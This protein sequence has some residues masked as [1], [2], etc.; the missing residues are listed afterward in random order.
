[1]QI[2]TV[3][4]LL[5]LG[6]VLR[7][8][9]VG[10]WRRWLVFSASLVCLYWLQ[11]GLPIRGLAYWLP[12]ATLGLTAL[13][14]LLT[15]KPAARAGEPGARREDLLAAAGVV[16]AALLAGLTR[17]LGGGDWLLASA[18]PPLLQT[19]VGVSGGA[20]LLVVLGITNK[21]RALPVWALSLAIAGLVALLVVVKTPALALA[22]ARGLR[23]LAG[24]NPTLAA[25]LDV[26][27]LGFSYISFRLIHALRD[28]QN[29]RLPQAGLL[30]TIS[31]VIFFP[32]LLAGPIDRLERFDKDFRRAPGAEAHWKSFFELSEPA[33]RILLGLVKKFVLADT[34]GLA[35][36][37][38]LNAGQVGESGWMWLLVYL[39]AWQI[40]LDFA[41]YTDIAIGLGLLV[42]IKLPENF[43]APYLKPNLTQFWNA[44]HISLTQWFRGYFFNPFVRWLRGPK[45]RLK[46]AW[47][48]LLSQFATMGLIGLWH[49]VAV[50]FL[51][52][53]L[54][55]GLGL[56]V[57]NRWSD[58]TKTWFAAR[59]FSPAARRA[60]ALGS[61]LLTFHYVALGWVFFA[62]PD[63]STAL[64][65][66]RVLF[67][68]R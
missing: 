15:R 34:L 43:N 45:L 67:G 49:G 11:P 31:Y 6:L 62:L 13:T 18:P 65:V 58:A 61:G 25:G 21:G 9:P 14:W 24:Q 27:W 53:G 22:A 57:Q 17:Y 28:R 4:L 59:S 63:P 37:S 33:R 47:V 52:W 20:L 2:T 40:Y 50:N 26:R 51:L 66:L 32:A 39:Y 29:G 38:P 3:F 35:A 41:G 23:L 10:P 5:A 55:H 64:R 19:A 44:W 7:V 68:G 8:V 54:W 42:G 12:T 1:M 36:L 56:F 48:L 30:D 16:L 46:P 60:L